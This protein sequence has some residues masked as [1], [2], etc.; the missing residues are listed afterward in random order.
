MANLF[1]NNKNEV[2]ATTA[3]T[4][5][6]IC[7][8]LFSKPRVYANVWLFNS[9]AKLQGHQVVLVSTGG[10]I[11]HTLNFFKRKELILPFA[12]IHIHE[13]YKMLDVITDLRPVIV[14]SAKNGVAAANRKFNKIRK[15]GA[16]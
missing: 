16:K 3:V 13:L 15:G 2:T 8:F 7:N 14:V 1:L 5:N 4:V 12:N 9:V 11:I 6:D 10:G